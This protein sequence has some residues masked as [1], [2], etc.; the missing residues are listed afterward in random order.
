M[1][2]SDPTQTLEDLKPLITEN[3]M[4]RQLGELPDEWFWAD[5]LALELGA[6]TAYYD[7]VWLASRERRF[8]G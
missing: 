8:N 4:R 5:V 2:R 1:D 6:D 3:Y 7:A